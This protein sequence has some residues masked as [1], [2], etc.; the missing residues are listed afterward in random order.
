[1]STARF[2]VVAVLG[3]LLAALLLALAVVLEAP[4]LY[5]PAMVVILVI[6][7]AREGWLWEGDT[8]GW[9]TM[10]GALAMSILVAFTLQRLWN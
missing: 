4:V 8:R 6:F 9:L 5:G 7:V 3:G 2:L 1:V 10:V